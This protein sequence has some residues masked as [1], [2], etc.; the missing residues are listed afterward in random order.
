[1]EVGLLADRRLI[2]AVGQL[3]GD[4][5]PGGDTADNG[6][7]AHFGDRVDERVVAA[8][9][10][11]SHAAQVTVQ[12]AIGP[13]TAR[14]GLARMPIKPGCGSAP[15]G[16]GQGRCTRHSSEGFRPSISKPPWPSAE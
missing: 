3:D 11:S 1:L 15:T 14:N 4:M 2:D 6:F 7:W 9:A 13:I 8:A 5:Q 12:L 10:A 16:R